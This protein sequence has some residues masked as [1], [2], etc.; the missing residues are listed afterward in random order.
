VNI[1]VKEKDEA[2]GKLMISPL[3]PP[4]APLR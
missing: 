4:Y 2:S 3:A 1:A